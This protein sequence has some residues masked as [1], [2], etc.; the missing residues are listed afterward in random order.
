MSSMAAA[1]KKASCEMAKAGAMALCG[2]K[3]TVAINRKLIGLQPNG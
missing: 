1:A 2:D 3:R